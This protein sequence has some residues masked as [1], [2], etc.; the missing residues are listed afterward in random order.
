VV[1]HSSRRCAGLLF[2]LAFTAGCRQRVG[3]SV[4]ARPN[5]LLIS[6]DALRADRLGIYGYEPPTSPFLD[7]LARSGTVYERAFVAT[8]GTTPSHTTMLSG[9]YQEAHGVGLERMAEGVVAAGIP[10]AVPLL[11]EQLRAAGY[12]TIGITDGGNIGRRFGF[13]R[14]FE[15]FDDKGGGLARTVPLLLNELARARQAQPGRPVF[16]FLHTYDVHS[17]YRP[18]PEARAA[19]AI[20]ESVVNAHTRFL[21]RNS[22]NP[23]AMGASRLAEVSAL[24]DAE[25][26]GVDRHLRGLFDALEAVDFLDHSLVLITSDH[27]E[28]FGEHGGLLHGAKLYDELMRVPLLVVGERIPRGARG[29]RLI[30]A[31]DLVPSILDHVGVARSSSLVGRPFLGP[32]ALERVAAVLAQYGRRLYAVRT[33]RWKLIQDDA[34]RFELYDLVADPGEE[35][36]VAPQYGAVRARLAGVIA[37][38]RESQ[39]RVAGTAPAVVLDAEETEKLRSLGYLG[40]N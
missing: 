4:A 30:S 19:L 29:S 39:A 36:N 8:H 20:P 1:H 34:G 40:G 16:A 26:R 14:G 3:D 12:S 32:A 6:I 10:D 33:E 11:Q 37:R 23:A 17:P 22:R 18:P 38:F 21:L 28:E 31:V 25:I 5:V 15:S 9:F 27:G 13:S 35:S 2:L 24:Y 7:E